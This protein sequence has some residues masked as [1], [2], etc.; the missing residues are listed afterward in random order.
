[1]IMCVG[2]VSPVFGVLFARSRGLSAEVLFSG[3]PILMLREVLVS[4][5]AVT[6][7]EDGL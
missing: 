7:L 6:V 1:M 4:E 3:I 5:G 2:V